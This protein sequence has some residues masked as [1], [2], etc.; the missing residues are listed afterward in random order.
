MTS[1]FSRT[2]IRPAT[3]LPDEAAAGMDTGLSDCH[4]F[5]LTPNRPETRPESDEGF[6]SVTMEVL[7]TGSRVFTLTPNLLE[8][9]PADDAGFGANWEGLTSV[10]L[11]ILSFVLTF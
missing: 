9:L 8:S 1:C 6:K 4:C 7:V 10:V 11:E 2:L 5:G 3:R